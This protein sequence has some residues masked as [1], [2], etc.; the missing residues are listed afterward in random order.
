MKRLTVFAELCGLVSYIKKKMEGA[1]HVEQE[2]LN[3]QYMMKT[4]K[5][6]V[7]V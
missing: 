1:L 7:L 4:I 3:C 2:F 6:S 5:S